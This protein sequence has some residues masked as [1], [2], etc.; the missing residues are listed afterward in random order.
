MLKV[1]QVLK[2]FDSKKDYGFDIRPQYAKCLAVMKKGDKINSNDF[3]KTHKDEFTQ[4]RNTLEA[5]LAVV[6]KAISI[7]KKIGILKE[8][9]N[10]SVP[11]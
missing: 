2:K 6:Y 8:I 10:Y 7:G 11:I 1:Y 4:R 9:P 3:A 5:T